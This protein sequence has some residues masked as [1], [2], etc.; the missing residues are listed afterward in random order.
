MGA[1]FHPSHPQALL[2]G[3]YTRKE[4]H[5]AGF[6]WPVSG[7]NG[8]LDAGGGNQSPLCSLWDGDIM[9][10]V[11]SGDHIMKAR[12][13]TGTNLLSKEEPC[14]SPFLK[15][16]SIHKGTHTKTHTCITNLH[17]YA[18]TRII[19]CYLGN[20]SPL[21][22]TINIPLWVTVM[23]CYMSLMECC[24]AELSPLTHSC[25]HMSRYSDQPR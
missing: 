24:P 16:P 8:H 14:G 3:L 7:S 12:Q 1:S 6:V 2:W 13:S 19:L 9:Q 20:H 10:E 15:R 23:P 11:Q 17:T 21:T 18:C 4:R 25:C 22:C 5:Y